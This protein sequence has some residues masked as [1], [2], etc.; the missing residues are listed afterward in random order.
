MS[1]TTTPTNLDTPELVI[2]RELN[3]PAELV[4]KAWT[5]PEHLKHWWGPKGF[6]VET[7]SINVQPGGRFHYKMTGNGF[8][9]YGLFVYREVQPFTRL[10]FVNSF[11]D[12]E[13][14]IISHPMAPD[15][16]LEVLNELV[17]S[18][19]DGITTL[20]LKGGPINAPEAALTMFR[21]NLENVQQGFAGTFEQLVAYLDELTGKA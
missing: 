12:A 15:W 18:E 4:F 17:L 20:T 3:A 8:E 9:A 14:G 19:T 1:Q 2:I 10:V 13:G 6:S 16:P 7:L 5:E 21:S 11:S